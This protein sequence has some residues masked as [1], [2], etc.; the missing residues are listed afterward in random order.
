MIKYRVSYGDSILRETVV[1]ASTAEQALDMVRDEIGF[2][3][4]HHAA[5]VWQDDW[6]AEPYQRPPVVNRTCCECGDR[7]A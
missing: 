2:G 4:H 5:D 3:K 6:A 1:H 7:R